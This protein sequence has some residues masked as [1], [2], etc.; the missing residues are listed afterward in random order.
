MK[1]I[2][3]IH[4]LSVEAFIGVQAWEKKIKQPVIFNIDI[5]TDTRKAADSDNLSDTIAYDVIVTR[6]IELCD[7]KHFNLL[8]NLT[9]TVSK[10]ILEEFGAPWTRIQSSKPRALSTAKNAGIIIERGNKEF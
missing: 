4:E 3:Y 5:A 1:D 6:I 7:T 8:E 9:E 2:I 10:I